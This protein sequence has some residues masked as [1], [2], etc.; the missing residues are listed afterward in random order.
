[1]RNYV[2][3]GVIGALI[4]L[5]GVRLAIGQSEEVAKIMRQKLSYA[6]AILEG[7]STEDYKKITDSAGAMLAL[8]HRVEWNVIDRPE[9]LGFS[10]EFRR[11]LDE[12]VDSAQRRS[13]D[14]VAYDYVQMTMACVSCHRFVRGVKRA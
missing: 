2:L 10:Q 5:L 1:M 7:V 14:G 3:A 12:L 6:Q 9:Y 11:A 13:A 8:T 4:T